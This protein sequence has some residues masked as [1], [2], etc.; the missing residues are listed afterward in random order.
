MVRELLRLGINP[1]I[2]P[3]PNNIPDGQ[4]QQNF[5]YLLTQ[6]NQSLTLVNGKIPSVKDP[7]FNAVGDGIADDT[8]AI[9]AAL[10]ASSGNALYFPAGNYRVTAALAV[11][12]STRIFGAGWGQTIITTASATADVFQINA[13]LCSI[14]GLQITSS[15]TRTAGAYVRVNAVAFF[16]MEEFRLLNGFNGIVNNG[17]FTTFYLNGSIFGT[18]TNGTA[19]WLTG[20]PEDCYVN[21]VTVSANALVVGGTGIRIDS[22]G[23]INI[24]DCDIIRHSD[25]L[26]INPEIFSQLGDGKGRQGNYVIGLPGGVAQ[27]QIFQTAC[28]R[29]APALPPVA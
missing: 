26:L 13:S 8:A 10:N 7:P 27:N 21:H 14:R 15:A 12:F 4:I 6:L 2:N 11:N 3:Y 22:G 16:L 5:L 24:T 9:Q 25:A 19:I 1:S 20:A 23:A 29:A 17:A 18:K 28:A